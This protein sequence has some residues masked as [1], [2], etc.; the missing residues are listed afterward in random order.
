MSSSSTERNGTVPVLH[1]LCT[2]AIYVVLPS[3]TANTCRHRYVQ[4]W[5]TAYYNTRSTYN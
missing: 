5:T 3:T 1:I 4:Q 2:G